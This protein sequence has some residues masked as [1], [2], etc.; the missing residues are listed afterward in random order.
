MPHLL[1]GSHDE[2]R[3]DRLRHILLLVALLA[4][5]SLPAQITGQFQSAE[6]T[7]SYAESG[8]GDAVVMLAVLPDAGHFAWLEA[9]SRLSAEIEAFLTD[10]L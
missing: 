10:P 8:S 3:M 4:A 9:P 7:M 5:P 1:A 2:L 6:L